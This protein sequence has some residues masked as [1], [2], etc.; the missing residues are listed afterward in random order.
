MKNK[1]FFVTVLSLSVISAVF[2]S[3]NKKSDNNLHKLMG[4]TQGT[5]Y[6]VTYYSD[7][8]TNL[9]N[10]IDSLLIA[11]D[12]IFSTF[13]PNSLVSKINRNETDTITDSL[14]VEVWNKSM[15]VSELSGGDFDITVGP[16]VN[17]W[18]FGNIEKK[19][20]VSKSQIDSVLKITGYKKTQLVD[21]KIVKSDANIQINFNAIAQGFSVD[22]LGEYL[23]SKGIDN[24]LVDI[25]G[26]IWAKG[27]KPDGKEWILAIE[28]PAKDKDDDRDIQIQFPL[29]DKSI[30]TSGSYRKY[31]EE[32]G[33]RYSHTI[34]PHTGFPV[35]HSLL[36]VSVIH[37]NCM[38][39]DALCTMFM[40]K[41]LDNSLDFLKQYPEL[42]VYFIYSD[43]SG[44][45]QTTET[46]AFSKLI[47]D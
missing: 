26:E 4:K 45:I 9:Q 22:L 19:D 28:K 23:I 31:Y 1:M 15:E 32:N 37:D 42:P 24:F 40:V 16:L 47:A 8:T 14:F 33:I 34:N 13:N 27:T 29:K 6:A 44:N 38:T 5:Y 36:S 18:G 11:F 10:E 17:I 25:G 43:S 35:E 12:G 30:S 21:N 46:D 20:N 39:A 2:L 7:D 3:C 41:G